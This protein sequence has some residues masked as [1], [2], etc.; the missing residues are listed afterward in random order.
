MGLE[1]GREPAGSPHQPTMSVSFCCRTCSARFFLPAS[2]SP[3][4][5]T[6]CPRCRQV[7]LDDSPTPDLVLPPPPPPILPPPST[8]S[9]TAE[10]MSSSQDLLPPPLPPWL[11]QG[12]ASQDPWSYLFTSSDSPPRPPPPIPRVSLSPS[13][14]STSTLPRTPVSP[15]TRPSTSTLLPTSRQEPWDYFLGPSDPVDDTGKEGPPSNMSVRQVCREFR[16][17]STQEEQHRSSPAISPLSSAYSSAC[18]SPP[19]ASPPLHQQHRGELQPESS[20]LALSSASTAET[21]PAF[22]DLLPP[23]P[24]PLPWDDE[25]NFSS[26]D[27]DNQSP[28]RP[29][30]PPPFSAYDATFETLLQ[31]GGSR[32]APPPVFAYQAA[33]FDTPLQRGGSPA[34]PPPLSAYD[35]TF[36]SPIQRGGSQAAPAESIAALPTVIVTDNALVCPICTDPLLISAPA[37]RLPCGHLYHS[38]CIV[39]WLAL[40]NSC[41]VCRGSIPMFYSTATDIASSPSPSTDPT[42]PAG[43]RRFL[44]GGRRIRRICSRLLR[45][46]EISQDRQTNSSRDRQTDSSGD[47]RV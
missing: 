34:A 8:T 16:V 20:P 4:L 14:S 5:F 12:S 38:D 23:P 1:A 46:T 43:R 2:S 36:H 21:T 47:V 24:P 3:F 22:Q 11:L 15:C 28:P 19:L 29:P 40:R 37:R 33:T 7:Y 31:R 44:P 27:S 39:T 17:L 6:L 30:P 25:Y 13:S 18:S 45:R 32:A 35:A 41:P 10:T 26:S 42:P 9:T